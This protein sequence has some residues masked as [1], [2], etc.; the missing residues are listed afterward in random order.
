MPAQPLPRGRPQSGALPAFGGS[1]LDA[2]FRVAPLSAT[3]LLA[4]APL[5]RSR[6]RGSTWSRPLQQRSHFP[7]LALTTSFAREVGHQYVWLACY[8]MHVQLMSKRHHTAWLIRYRYVLRAACCG[9]TC[10]SCDLTTLSRDFRFRVSQSSFWS[11]TYVS[12]RFDMYL[13]TRLR[14]DTYAVRRT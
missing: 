12:Q 5:Q 6:S 10:F 3:T 2:P 14:T 7:L 8:W 11:A 1:A 4:A 9:T 13:R